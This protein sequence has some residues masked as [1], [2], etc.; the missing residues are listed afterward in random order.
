VSC[1]EVKKCSACSGETPLSR[2]FFSFFF[3]KSHS[4]IRWMSP[5]C[6]TFAAAPCVRKVPEWHP[7]LGSPNDRLCLSA[8]RHLP[9]YAMRLV[10]PHRS[11]PIVQFGATPFSSYIHMVDM[12]TVSRF[13]PLG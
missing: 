6:H 2:A 10:R 4:M 5:E 11:H 8:Q 7:T 12:L 1:K 13:L 3:F 9:I